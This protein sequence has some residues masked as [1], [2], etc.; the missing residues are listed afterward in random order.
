MRHTRPGGEHPTIKAGPIPGAGMKGEPH[1]FSFLT[2]AALGFAGVLVLGVLAMVLWVVLL[3]FK[4]LG[5]AL[6][7]IAMLLWLPVLLLFGVLGAVI[8]GFG[9]LI[10]FFPLVPF[11]LL[12]LLVWWLMR[13]KNRSSATVTS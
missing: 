13:R 8:F 6:R 11:A 5:L 3:P 2:L 1:V 12:A 4:I 10:F 9:A 7:G